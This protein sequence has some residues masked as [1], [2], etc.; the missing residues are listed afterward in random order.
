MF[1]LGELSAQ[2]DGQ[3]AA[4]RA[5]FA[6]RFAEFDTKPTRQALD[7]MLADLES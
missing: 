4:A 3:R 7:A 5:E 6:E 1:A 2:I